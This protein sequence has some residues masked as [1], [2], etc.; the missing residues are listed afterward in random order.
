MRSFPFKIF[1]LSL[2]L[3]PVLYAFSVEYLEQK[4][5]TEYLE[6]V[7]DIYIGETSPLFNGTVSIKD[8]VNRNITRYLQRKKFLK[9]GVQLNIVVTTRQ[10]KIL[11]PPFFERTKESLTPPDPMKVASENYRLLNE[12]LIVHIGVV[13]EHGKPV[14]IL[15]LFVYIGFSLLILYV[16][17]RRAIRYAK[18]SE[19]EK[20]RTIDRLLSRRKRSIETLKTL[21]MKRIELKNRYDQ[22]R[23][24]LENEKRKASRNEDGMLEEIMALEAEINRNIDLQQEQQKVIHDLKGRI[25][26]SDKGEEKGQE[27]VLKGAASVK[28]RFTALYKN[29]L[30]NEKAIS[31]F[32]NLPEDM[33][34]K[35]E[36]VIHHLNEKPDRVMIKR[37]V[38]SKKSHET[39]LEVLFAYKGR[40]YF[41]MLKDQRVEVLII[42]T[43]NTEHKDLEFM[44]RL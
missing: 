11:F 24:E 5:K 19:A 27:K 3:P 20:T 1:I 26:E 36:E 23:Q 16:F 31:G 7:K 34:I 41:R 38:F 18:T 25:Q 6:E 9:W 42:G 10:G 43:K 30:V 17:T 44:D 39:V 4:I 33:K 32:I 29:I 37:K 35:C 13:L 22:V 15:I 40:L 28:K 14:S 21:R 12:G 2:L 8:A